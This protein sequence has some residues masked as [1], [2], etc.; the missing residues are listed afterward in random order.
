VHNGER[1]GVDGFDWVAMFYTFAGAMAE[2]S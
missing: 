2:A 1:F